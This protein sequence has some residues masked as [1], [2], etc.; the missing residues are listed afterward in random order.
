LGVTALAD[1]AEYS[2][3]VQTTDAY[4]LHDSAMCGSAEVSF[5]GDLL[6]F[7]ETF[8]NLWVWC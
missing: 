6:S 8:G 2:I 1:R 5:V 7:A 4:A 3:E